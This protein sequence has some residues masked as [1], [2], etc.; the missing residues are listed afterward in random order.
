MTVAFAFW[1]QKLFREGL[2]NDTRQWRETNDLAK[3]T[4]GMV[5]R[6]FAVVFLLLSLAVFVAGCILSLWAMSASF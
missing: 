4:I 3:N 2:D 6:N 1:S 5:K